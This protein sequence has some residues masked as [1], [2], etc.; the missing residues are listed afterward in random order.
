MLRA[1]RGPLDNKCEARGSR[2]KKIPHKVAWQWE[3][4]QRWR[5]GTFA[6]LTT[7]TVKWSSL[8]RK[9]LSKTYNEEK[10]SPP[11]FNPWVL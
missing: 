7:E 2:Q 9:L 3:E 11:S 4:R 8:R 5:P 10:Q 1:T 6:E